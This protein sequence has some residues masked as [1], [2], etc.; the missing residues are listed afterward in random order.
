MTHRRSWLTSG[1]GLLLLLV[2]LALVGLTASASVPATPAPDVAAPQDI[3]YPVNET[4]ESGTLGVFT[5]SAPICSA[6]TCSWT[7]STAAPF[8]GTY[9][10]RASNN[11]TSTTSTAD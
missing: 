2:A 5:A 1:V 10:A 8:N 11:L 9:A 4:F 7:A 3:E 6:G